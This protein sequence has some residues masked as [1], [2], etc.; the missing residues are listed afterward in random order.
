MRKVEK[1]IEKSKGSIIILLKR[2]TEEARFRKLA[3]KDGRCL[4]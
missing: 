4:S 3:W 2:E 1:I